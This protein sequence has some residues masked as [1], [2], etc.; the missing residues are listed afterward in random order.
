MT[1]YNEPTITWVGDA[2]DAFVAQSAFKFHTAEAS[3]IHRHTAEFNAL[4][5]VISKVWS[6]K[7]NRLRKAKNLD[8]DHDYI[9]IE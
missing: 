4:A 8:A 9:E 6:Q 2:G 7:A 3:S 1:Y 5:N